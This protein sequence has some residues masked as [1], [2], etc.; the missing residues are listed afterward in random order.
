MGR[1]NALQQEC[2]AL[3]Q[4]C[5]QLEESAASQDKFWHSQL[6]QSLQ[7]LEQ[8][9]EQLRHKP[10]DAPSPAVQEE[11]SKS[12]SVRTA[13]DDSDSDVTTPKSGTPRSDS[14]GPGSSKDELRAKNAVATFNDRIKVLL[15]RCANDL[16]AREARDSDKRLEDV[17]NQELKT[18]EELAQTVAEVESVRSVYDTL[19]QQ[20]ARDGAEHMVVV[21]KLEVAEAD[22]RQLGQEFA[23]LSMEYDKLKE[24]SKDLEADKLQQDR[25]F[26][27][28]QQENKSLRDDMERLLQ[29]SEAGARAHTRTY[30]Y[31]FRLCL[32]QYQT[33]LLSNFVCVHSIRINS[34]TMSHT[35]F[36]LYILYI[37]IVLSPIW[38]I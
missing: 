24:V 31:T 7:E 10:I 21:G 8:H 22:C 34:T 2:Q 6:E 17:R 5:R 3:R 35:F 19:T 38:L 30:I 14:Q 18:R 27:G 1:T 15:E 26:G 12:A 4:R 37:Y 9:G 32:S 13:V 11:D 33:A 25:A 23:R 36:N 28:L 16:L 29:E 20:N